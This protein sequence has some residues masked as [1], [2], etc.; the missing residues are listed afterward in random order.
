LATADKEFSIPKS[1]LPLPLFYRAKEPRPRLPSFLRECLRPFCS[2]KSSPSQRI[3]PLL[4]ILFARRLSS[5]GD[6]HP[7][8]AEPFFFPRHYPLRMGKGALP[9]G[10]AVPLPSRAVVPVFFP[11]SPKTTFL[12]AWCPPLRFGNAS[13]RGFLFFRTC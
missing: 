4:E 10:G 11:L 13:M 3:R 7:P 2:W 6:I 8:L 5:P 1:Y 9:V 12:D